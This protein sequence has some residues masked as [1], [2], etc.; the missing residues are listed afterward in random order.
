MHLRVNGK[1]L[2]FV[3]F[4]FIFFVYRLSQGIIFMKT[5]CLLGK[6]SFRFMVAAGSDDDNDDERAR[7]KHSRLLRF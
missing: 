4:C 3:L 5:S 7:K 6:F 1:V 2:Y